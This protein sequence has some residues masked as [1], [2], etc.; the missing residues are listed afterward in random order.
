MLQ[1]SDSTRTQAE[2]NNERDETQKKANDQRATG[3]VQ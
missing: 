3:S 1:L 2:E